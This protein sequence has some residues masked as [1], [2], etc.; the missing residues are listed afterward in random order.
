MSI[1]AT[2]VFNNWHDNMHNQVDN[3][4]ITALSKL[5]DALFNTPNSGPENIVYNSA[6]EKQ[7]Q[8]IINR[9]G[10]HEYFDVPHYYVK[11][12]STTPLQ[13]RNITTRPDHNWVSNVALWKNQYE[14]TVIY[15]T[16][17]HLPSGEL[18]NII[19]SHEELKTENPS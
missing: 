15:M 16:F 11:E 17:E 19:L 8:D 13:N 12:D 9:L 18:G 7:M 5:I 10:Y 14:Q 1:S 3:T 6:I 2:G 4:F